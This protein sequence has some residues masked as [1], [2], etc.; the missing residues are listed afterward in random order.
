[1][2]TLPATFLCKVGDEIDFSFAIIPNASHTLKFK[3]NSGLW[4]T[5][6]TVCNT[7]GT[8]NVSL[9]AINEVSIVSTDCV[10]VVTGEQVAILFVGGTCKVI[11]SFYI[12]HLTLNL[13]SSTST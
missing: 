3:V 13:K 9:M 8:R 10:C 11:T 5:Q 4:L 7:A 2:Q 1:M 6:N 12:I